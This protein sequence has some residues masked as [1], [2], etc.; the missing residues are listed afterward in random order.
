MKL[1]RVSWIMRHSNETRAT[2]CRNPRL[3]PKASDFHLNSYQ[4]GLYAV[5]F[6][7]RGS[8]RFELH[9]TLIRSVPLETQAKLK[10]IRQLWCHQCKEV[11]RYQKEL[12][13]HQNSRCWKSAPPSL[14]Q[15][16]TNISFFRA[17]LRSVSESMLVTVWSILFRFLQNSWVIEIKSLQNFRKT[18]HN[19]IFKNPFSSSSRLS[20]RYEL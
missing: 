20:C 5:R 7:S 2:P 8:V 6:R 9:Y 3:S 14:K 4:G 10:Q 19:H 18:G 13:Q 15:I 11:F 16:S 1:M 12:T 17:I